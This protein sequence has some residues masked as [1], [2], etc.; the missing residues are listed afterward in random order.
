MINYVI[1]LQQD[2]VILGILC[3]QLFILASVLKFAP[4]RGFAIYK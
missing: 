1:I 2:Y 4:H 3:L